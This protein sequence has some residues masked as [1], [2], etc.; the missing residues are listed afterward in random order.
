M[1]IASQAQA[2]APGS[3]TTRRPGVDKPIW[4]FLSISLRRELKAYGA[5]VRLA[6]YLG[7]PRQR[8]TDYVTGRRRMPDAELTLALLHW[9]SAQQAGRDLSR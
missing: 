5:K 1:H 3:F 4:S 2:P 9:L 8:V 7:L 6:R